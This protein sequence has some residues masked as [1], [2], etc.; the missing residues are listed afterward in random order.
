MKTEDCLKNNFN[1]NVFTKII[2]KKKWTCFCCLPSLISEHQILCD[3]ILTRSHNMNSSTTPHKRKRCISD[4][5]E[6]IRKRTHHSQSLD[7][8]S[9]DGDDEEFTITESPNLQERT[10]KKELLRKITSQLESLF[11]DA[12]E[13]AK[14]FDEKVKT[15]SLSLKV[16]K[17][18]YTYAYKLLVKVKNVLSTHENELLAISDQWEN[19]YRIQLIEP[20]LIVKNEPN[21]SSNNN[22]ILESKELNTSTKKKKHCLSLKRTHNTESTDDEL[23]NEIETDDTEKSQCKGLSEANIRA[24]Y[25]KH[26]NNGDSDH[27][28]LYSQCTVIIDKDAIRYKKDSSRY[29]LCEVT[30]NFITKAKTS[31]SADSN[32]ISVSGEISNANSEKSFIFNLN[33]C[34]SASANNEPEDSDR[35]EICDYDNAKPLTPDEHETD[36]NTEIDTIQIESEKVDNLSDVQE[37]ILKHG[38]EDVNQDSISQND[39]MGDNDGPIDQ[40]IQNSDDTKDYDNQSRDYE[41]DNALTSDCIGDLQNQNINDI[42]DTTML[43]PNECVEDLPNVNMHDNNTLLETAEI[44]NC[45]NNDDDQNIELKTSNCDNTQKQNVNDED[46]D[47]MLED[48]IQSLTTH[49]KD[50]NVAVEEGDKKEETFIVLDDNTSDDTQDNENAKREYFESLGLSMLD[51]KDVDLKYE[52]KEEDN[53]IEIEEETKDEISINSDDED[54]AVSERIREMCKFLREDD[55]DCVLSDSSSGNTSDSNCSSFDSED[56]DLSFILKRKAKS[57]PISAQA[58][59]G[60]ADNVDSDDEDCIINI[61]SIE[62]ED[63]IS[64]E[65]QIKPCSVVL[66]DVHAKTTHDNSNASDNELR[67]I[68]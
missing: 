52:V 66:E 16:L 50:N 40:V 35:T 48:N 39:Q 63:D 22:N 23:N 45:L 68:E 46:D 41:N 55:F 12:N 3:K 51:K 5:S 64:G 57:K 10:E 33:D 11:H 38:A 17:N 4:S 58:G 30:G 2:K 7:D 28:S 21:D 20:S 59:N 14:E 6:K 60:E 44:T 56:S 1:E 54:V 62:N 36:N 34:I 29:I 53:N 61:D 26:N 13:N 8:V 18:A 42:D 15:Q 32:V 25:Q 9:Y 65:Y 67:D 24:E 37:E 19:D 31:N 27:D 49:Y 43:E 47:T